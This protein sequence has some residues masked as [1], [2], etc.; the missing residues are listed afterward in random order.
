MINPKDEGRNLERQW[1]KGV[2]VMNPTKP[3]SHSFGP[4]TYSICSL[5]E[6]PICEACLLPGIFSGKS[7]VF[8]FPI[9]EKEGSSMIR[10]ILKSFCCS[11]GWSYGIFWG[12]DQK[13]FLLLTLQDSYYE[14]QMGDVIENMLLQVH[15]FGGG[16]VGQAAFTKSHRW[17]FSDAHHERQNSLALIGSPDI[18]QDD[19]E[20]YCQFS[21]GIKTIVVISVEPFGVVQFGSTEKIPEREEFVDQV[22]EHFRGM[23]KDQLIVLSENKSS[24][25][26][27]E[28]FAGY[29]DLM[30][31][32]Y[33]SVIPIQSLPS[34]SSHQSMNSLSSISSLFE[35]QTRIGSKSNNEMEQ[36]LLETAAYFDSST[37]PAP[38][39]DSGDSVVTS[40]WHYLPPEQSENASFSKLSSY[41]SCRDSNLYPHG[42][43]AFNSLHNQHL[44]KEPLNNQNCTLLLPSNDC[45]LDDFSQWLS[46][47][48][49][50][51]STS[52]A[53]T[54][55][56][57]KSSA[58]GFTP[59]F[60]FR[61]HNSTIN[62]L[63]N[64][65]SNSIQSSI[66]ES[67][68][69]NGKKKFSD[70]SGI[71]RLCDGLGMEPGSKTSEDWSEIL[72]P[73]VNGGNLDF[74]MEN[75]KCISE[76]YIGSKVE[77]PNSLFSKL[78]LDY[79]LGGTASSSCS[80]AR[81]RFEDQ[82]SSTAK[83]RKIDDHYW[84]SDRVKFR[85]LPS[86][87]GK[88]KSLNPLYDPNKT[89]F[90]EPNYEASTKGGSLIGGDNGSMNNSLKGNEGP[91][92]M[93]KKKAKPGTRPRPKDR[94]QIQDRLVE[95]RQLIPNGEKMSIDRLL[96]QTIRH[97]NFMQSLMKHRE[98]LKKTDSPM[99][100]NSNGH[101]VGVTWACEVGDQ[102]MLCPLIVKDLSSPGQM[103]IETLC[104]EQ[105]FFLEIIDVI[106]N[107]GL[108]ILKGV[109][110]VQET[111]IWAHFIVEAEGNSH[112]TRHE[113][114][115][116]LIQLFQ[117]SPGP[118]SGLNASDQIGD[119]YSSGASLFNNCQP[120]VSLPIIS[121]DSLQHTSL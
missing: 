77:N 31:A 38:S 71:D 14:E 9:S 68:N 7:P 21:T 96:Q 18:F 90:L 120:V 65:P 56:N 66:T 104:D 84:N 98:S 72:M 87:D 121:A 112:V 101:D 118:T 86:Y 48:P 25:L 27:C 119:I 52:F 93:M 47:L 103:L 85:G 62:V 35:N 50:E 44:S 53:T 69:S 99:I 45:K 100:D 116:S 46:P 89:S 51:S 17:I 76:Q 13:N 78:G 34:R 49:D 10:K 113:I 29:E 59:Q 16:V 79:L 109:M 2:P 23:S 94:Q 63:E 19:S 43:L 80:S 88:M 75:S 28:I 110:E 57:G 39:S 40:S 4:T 12:F 6:I 32:N 36:L 42:N 91:A 106:R 24:S 115:S 70:M 107:F 111:K 108:I 54:P 64:L 15:V 92:K 105:G 8:W 33:S 37:A 117:M 60:S 61:G 82:V 5:P 114:F 67:F 26:D 81:S 83:R 97:L 1:Q 41:E 58:T 20:F 30:D 11:N 22:K 95:L 55:G 73:V 3:T 74:S 102:S